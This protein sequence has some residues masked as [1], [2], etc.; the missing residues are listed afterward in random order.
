MTV[1]PTRATCALLALGASSLAATPVFA[2][3]L[4]NYTV[5]IVELNDSGV[6]GTGIL[7]LD[8]DANTLTVDFAIS[9]VE[10]SVDH[11]MHIHGRFDGSGNPLN[12]VVPT[13][14]DDADGDGYVEV[15]EGLPQY[16]DILLPFL[17][18]STDNGIIEYVDVFDL[19]DDDALMS[20]VSGEN[21][22]IADL[23]P[24][25]LR[26]FVI[27]GMSV[28]AGAGAGSDGEVDGSAGYKALLPVGAGQIAAATPVPLPAPLALLAAVAAPLLARH[29][30][31]G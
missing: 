2:A 24:L 6:S 13:P 8:S 30:G 20:P 21:Y 27:H 5:D 3:H 1:K 12:S 18:Q 26:E 28:P 19:N 15:L 11:G 25:D 22:D 29:R 9:G 17:P 14:A 16:G 10:N 7:T 4:S 23:L 31:R